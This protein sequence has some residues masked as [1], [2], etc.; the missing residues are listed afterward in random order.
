MIRARYLYKFLE[1]ESKYFT[2]LAFF[3]ILFTV[4][5]F[6][7][8]G[9]TSQSNLIVLFLQ[10]GSLLL[11]IL[12]LLPLIKKLETRTAKILQIFNLL[13]LIVLGGLL[14]YLWYQYREIVIGL[15]YLVF[16]VVG[17]F[18]AEKIGKYFSFWI[19][20]DLIKL[21]KN[22][23]QNLLIILIF[24]LILIPNL[25]F[26]YNQRA[27]L[28]FV[29]VNLFSDIFSNL[30]PTLFIGYLFSFGISLLGFILGLFDKNKVKK[31]KKK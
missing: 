31:G 21:K 29:E 15:M 7:E 26:A 13:L 20:N 6:F 22:M 27:L 19:N 25:H 17:Y 2:S 10:S 3:V 9:E 1:D 28:P 18:H 23:W 24:F 12:C 11:L 8:L 4:T 5:L 14:G 16:I 30:L